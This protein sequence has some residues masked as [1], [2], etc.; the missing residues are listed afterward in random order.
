MT[1]TADLSPPQSTSLAADLRARRLR[2][3]AQRYVP[4]LRLTTSN[5]GTGPRS[6]GRC[7]GPDHPHGNRSRAFVVFQH[8]VYCHACGL[9]A[10]KA[11]FIDW[12][13]KH[14]I[15][16]LPT[17]GSAPGWGAPPVRPRRTPA[18]PQHP[19]PGCTLDDYAKA[20]RLPRA[21]LDGLGLSDVTYL[22]TPA[23]K[24][25]WR[26]P[27][28]N[29]LG[30]Q[31]RR[32]VT[33]TPGTPKFVTK[34]GAKLGLYGQEFIE[35]IK[36]AGGVQLVEG[37][38]DYQTGWLHQIPALGIPG[39][40]AWPACWARLPDDIKQ[41]LR[42]LDVLLW[43]EPD[44]MDLPGLVARDLPQVK[45]LRPPRGLKDLSDLHLAVDGDHTKLLRVVNRLKDRAVPW[46]TVQAE[47]TKAQRDAAWTACK[48]LARQPDILACVE[49]ALAKSGLVGEAR[50]AKLLFLA[51]TSARFLPRPISVAVKG[52]SA[53]GKNDVA[54][55]ALALIA[56]GMIVE[57]TS[58]SERSL[59]YGDAPL[60]HRTMLLFE[61]AGLAEGFQVYVVRS[62]I[63]EQRLRY[64]TTEKGPDGQFRTRTIEREGPTNLITTTTRVVIDA[65]M[66]TRV[67]SLPVNDSAA[68]TA[69]INHA[70]ARS[71]TQGI[72]PLVTD[73][74]ARVVDLKPWHAIQKWLAL[75]T[76]DVVI[77]WAPLI[78]P[79][80]A[81]VRL[82]RDFPL[83]L[84]FIRTH[85]GLH[86]ATRPKTPDGKV[87]A[88][89][90]D[91]A[92]VR[93]LAGDLIA[94]GVQASV[95]PVVRETVQ[96]L[97]GLLA[98]HPMKGQDDQYGVPLA[99]FATA[100]KLDKSTASRRARQ[101]RPYIRNLEERRGHPA[102]LALGDPL[103]KDVTLFPDPATVAAL[104]VY[105]GDDGTPPPPSGSLVR[106]KRRLP[107]RRHPRRSGGVRA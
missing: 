83:V 78:A 47:Q 11:G 103:P 7:P 27:Q 1:T 28:G 44:A 96:A 69:A 87:I 106:V 17:D 72:Q 14:Q 20:K 74:V 76:P 46:A 70:Q 64:E 5:N 101:A 9:D 31:F 57:L 10:D 26:D 85:A 38:S 51:A 36:A 2:E 63:S 8:R 105:G 6:R 52:P 81:A 97:Q 58:F 21:H 80:P 39:K 66:E 50:A 86:A 55:R 49:Q 65:E 104:Q 95:S 79:P 62:L 54:G 42:G 99:A 82:R 3:I 60:A 48:D 16:P 73:A 43:Q 41:T 102:R 45:I 35:Q 34:K 12:L 94:E 68:Q 84:D 91:Y 67:L 24:M 92:A 23:V 18:T 22:G 90:E 98:R 89:L 29:E 61:H 40:A 77:P 107:N 59:I 13:E 30:A 4:D 71:A 32:T 53:A 19:G 75:T 93:A 56:P 88:T 100:L 25:P 33:E 37:P 15:P